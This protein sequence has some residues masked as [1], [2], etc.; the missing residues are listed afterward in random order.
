MKD[1]SETDI[2]LFKGK[3]IFLAED[4]DLNAET[5]YYDIILMDIMMPNMNGIEATN[6]IRSMNRK[7]AQ[8]I[9]IIAKTANAFDED[10]QATKDAVM[11]EHLSKPLDSKEM[12][13]LI[14]QYRGNIYE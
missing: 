12:L 2:E 7:D 6:K 1:N 10:R 5:G 4:N 9:P 8:I 11:N 14:S 13:K 3:R